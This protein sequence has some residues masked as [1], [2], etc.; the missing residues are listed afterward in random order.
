MAKLKDINIVARNEYGD[1]I[2]IKTPV[3]VTKDG[4]F[5]TTLPETEM[6]KLDQYDVEMARNRLGRKGYFESKTLEGL[7]NDIRDTCLLAL[8]REKV[9]EKEVICYQV[10]TSGVC[11]IDEEGQIC[12]NGAWSKKKYNDDRGRWAEFNY[13]Q[14][15][16]GGSV[17]MMSVYAVVM[18]QTVYRFNSGKTVEELTRVPQPMKNDGTALGWLKDQVNVIP[19]KSTL[20]LDMVPATEENAK[21]FVSLLKSIYRANIALTALSKAEDFEKFIQENKTIFLPGTIDEQ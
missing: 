2:S 15:I 14:N 20:K 19:Y 6:T 16:F 8:S 10:I 9:S 21:I 12:P 18:K 3:S 11:Y 4:L 7:E 17:P 13:Q 5:V 1:S